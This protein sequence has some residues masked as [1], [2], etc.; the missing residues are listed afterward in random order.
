MWKKGAT[1]MKS[2]NFWYSEAACV[3]WYKGRK[4]VEGLGMSYT[5]LS[6]RGY[7]SR[8]R[9][10]GEI[11]SCVEVIQ[12]PGSSVPDEGKTPVWYARF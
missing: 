2:A 12:V 5:A 7:P 10:T 9:A 3:P 1:P 8:P 4:D 6:K 11:P